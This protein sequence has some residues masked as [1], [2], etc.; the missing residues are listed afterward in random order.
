MAKVP[1]ILGYKDIDRIV[2]VSG[3]SDDDLYTRATASKLRIPWGE[4]RLGKFLTCPLFTGHLSKQRR[5]KRGKIV[6][7]DAMPWAPV[8][9]LSLG[10][11]H[12]DI[13]LLRRSRVILRN[14]VWGLLIL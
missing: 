13:A 3:L 2:T 4:D 7:R 5:W 12:E 14:N 6:T 10:S 8:I 1:D 11:R 9:W